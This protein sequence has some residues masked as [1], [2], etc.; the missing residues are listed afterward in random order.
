MFTSPFLSVQIL[1]SL[2]LLG[3][4][5]F[6]VL[7]LLFFFG[8]GEI[9]KKVFSFLGHYALHAGTLISF[10]ALAGS[11][12]FSNAIGFVPCELCWVQRIFIYPQALLFAIALYKKDEAVVDYSLAL[13]SLGLI[14][15]LYHSYIQWGGGSLIPC[16]AEGAEC[17]KIFFME[18]GYITI[19]VMS[20][21]A[22]AY[23]L[24]LMFIR[25]RFSAGKI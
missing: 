7:L 9:Y 1:S 19:P 18:F 14:V 3:D 11:L 17:S 10:G 21:T 25:K 6:F 16:T 20:L 2:I 23:L 4:I 12:L 22:F 8:K 13:S 15:A 24:L 5:L